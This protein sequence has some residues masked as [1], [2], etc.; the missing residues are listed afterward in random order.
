MQ[1]EQANQ[2]YELTKSLFPYCTIF[3]EHFVKFKGQTLYFDFYIKELNILIEV[4]GEQHFSYNKYFHGDREGF[5][6]SKRRD[7]LKK[8]F[9]ELERMALVI[10]PFNE[11]MDRKKLLHKFSKALEKL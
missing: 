3:P 2:V 6:S 9:C 8:E 1:S 5:V 10:I 4:Q 11:K 7:N